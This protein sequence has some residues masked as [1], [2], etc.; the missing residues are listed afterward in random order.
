MV[1]LAFAISTEVGGE[2]L[3][4]DEV[5][6]AGDLAFMRKAKARIDGLVKGAS[7]LVLAS[8]DIAALRS[9]CSRL[10]LFDHGRIVFDGNVEEGIAIYTS[11]QEP[12]MSRGETVN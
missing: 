12:P 1:R 5:L 11:A 9:L 10:L 2:I 4:L 7:I 3:L 8:H 6:G